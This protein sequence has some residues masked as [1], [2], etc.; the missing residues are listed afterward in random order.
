MSDSTAQGADAPRSPLV[1][2]LRKHWFL[3]ALMIVIPLG[4]AVGWNPGSTPAAWGPPGDWFDARYLTAAVLFLMAFSLNSNKLV[5]AISKPGPVLWAAACNVALVPLLAWPLSYTQG[6]IDFR[7]GLMIAAASACTMA[8]A[9]VWTRQAGG[10]DAVSLLVTLSTNGL[11][12]LTAPAALLVTTGQSVEFDVPA[13]MVR[14]LLTAALPMAVGQAVRAIPAVGRLAAGRR[15]TWGN[16]ALFLVLGIVFTGAAKAGRTLDDLGVTEAD[17]GAQLLAAIAWVW[18]CCVFVH[19]TAMGVAYL[20]ARL[21]G[22]GRGEQIACAFAGSQKTLP[23]GLLIAVS[24]AM[25][26]DPN[27]LGPGRGV[28]LAVF[29][30]LMYHASQMFLDTVVASRFRADAPTVEEPAS[31]VA[32]HEEESAEG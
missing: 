18:A 15:A 23:I 5:A 1:E 13:L 21:F 9:S 14:L 20:G 6:L 2:V 8:G 22:F 16:L 26:G 10:N 29:P 11:C 19:A 3:A 24:P 32:L 27:L 7:L 12:F 17:G 28:P 31:P 30:M 25:F 4:L